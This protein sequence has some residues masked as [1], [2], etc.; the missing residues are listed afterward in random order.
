M[1]TPYV[2]SLVV[3]IL[4]LVAVTLVVWIQSE[5]SLRRMNAQSEEQNR[6]WHAR[7]ERTRQERDEA[8]GRS[9]ERGARAAERGERS[10]ALHQEAVELARQMVRN[11]ETIIALLQKLELQCK[12]PR[13]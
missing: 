6:E 2:V 12:E 9:A 1:P 3:F 10:L 4:F 13:K 5:R 11:Q 8:L 7:F